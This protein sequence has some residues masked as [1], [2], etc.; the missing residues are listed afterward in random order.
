M[1]ADSSNHKN[2][3]LHG[4]LH[5]ARTVRRWCGLLV[6]GYLSIVGL[7]AAMETLLVFPAPT[8]DKASLSRAAGAFG[9]TEVQTTTEDG[10]HLYGWRTG[11]HD[12][13]VVYFSGNGSSVGEGDLY[14]A[15]DGAGLSTL[16]INYRGY[17]G[18]EGSPSEGGLLLDAQA[19]WKEARKTHSADRIIVLSKSLGGGVAV[20]LAASLTD[21]QPGLLVLESTF[22]SVP[23]VAARSYPW[24]PVHLMMRNRFDSLSKAD[25]VRCETLVLH[26][27]SDEMIPQEQGRSLARA[28]PGAIF[29]GAPGKTHNERILAYRP[30]WSH[31]LKAALKDRKQ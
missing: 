8:T 28:I 17:P 18:S 15:L 4:R 12:R 10:V 14:R 3:D 11:T 1:M 16:H 7:M 2:K 21:E 31:F 30:I 24:L 26:G 20:G 25:K 23:D 27:S 29:M 22:T 19:A 13:L 6:L 9:A 5:G